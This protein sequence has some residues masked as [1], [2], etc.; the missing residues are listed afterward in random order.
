MNPSLM[1]DYFTP[2]FVKTTA[3][4]NVN[5]WKVISWCLQIVGTRSGILSSITQT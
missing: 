3:N 1:G 5:V 4:K 2:N